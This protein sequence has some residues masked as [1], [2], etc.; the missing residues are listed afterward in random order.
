MARNCSKLPIRIAPQRIAFLK[1][2]LEGYDGLAN[3]TTIDQRSGDVTI[4]YPM[5]QEEEVMQLMD[6]LRPSL[7]PDTF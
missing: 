5:E 1:F 2:I 4:N 6:A 7:L 3:L